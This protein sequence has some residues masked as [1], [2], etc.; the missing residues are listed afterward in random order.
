MERLNLDIEK[1]IKEHKGEQHK[2]TSLEGDWIEQDLATKAGQP[3]VDSGTG[4]ALIIRVFAFK[5]DPKTKG[6]DIQRSKSNKQEFFN[7]HATYIKNFLWKDGLRIR[8][9]HDPKMMFSEDGYK[10]AI[11]C[12]ARVGVSVDKKPTTL[13][14]ILSKFNKK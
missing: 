2:G 10:I 8:E 7:M 5:F 12:E 6:E 14:Q 4:K 3:L 13:Q 1:E 9:D 11:L